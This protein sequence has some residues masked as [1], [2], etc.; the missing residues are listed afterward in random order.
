MKK[1][2]YALFFLLILGCDGIE[3]EATPNSEII[4]LQI[5]DRDGE[6]TQGGIVGDGATTLM[7]R[8]NIPKNADNAFRNITF[9]T[10]EG[11]FEQTGMNT[12][13]KRVN[14]EGEASVIF[15]VPLSDDEIFFTAE[16]SS[17]E[18]VYNANNSLKLIDVDEVV[19]LAVLDS[20]EQTLNGSVRADGNTILTLSATVNFNQNNF[21]QVIFKN[22]GGG[23]FLGVNATEGR[24]NIDE[25]NT[26]L[27]QY[28]VPN[29]VGRIF[30]E[31]SIAANDFI[32]SKENL[33]LEPSYPDQMVLEPSTIS[34]A[35]GSNISIDAYLIKSIG[36]VSEGTRP[37]FKAFQLD[38]SNEEVPVGR[39]TGLPAAVTDGEGKVS[40]D[41]FADSLNM[42]ITKPIYIRASSQDDMG[43]TI[44]EQIQL[45]LTQ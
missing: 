14:T 33:D 5:L 36:K 28:Q 32:F 10:T 30:F 8:A 27:M 22:S 40:V 18:D 39:F 44:S 19:T 7:L 15:K 29:K 20:K 4:D 2:I 34:I 3:E 17:G 12:Q 43:D 23:S 41:F 13:T 31:A 16:I 26:A 42:D 25:N 45:E 6:P 21:N 35:L 37:D 11:I 1:F 24:A 9:S 38:D